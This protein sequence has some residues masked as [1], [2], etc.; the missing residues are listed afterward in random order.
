METTEKVNDTLRGEVCWFSA[1]K[2]FGFLSQ[3]NG[4][5][6]IFVHFSAVEMEGY[7]T[8]K[9]GQRVTYEVETGPK[10]KPQAARVK[11]IV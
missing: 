5:D 4:G 9:E 10:G 6:D 1:G 3:E 11:V 7:R 8:L 2:G